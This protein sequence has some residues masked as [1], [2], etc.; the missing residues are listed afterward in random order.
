[1]SLMDFSDTNNSMYQLY[2]IVHIFRM[3]YSIIG[4]ATNVL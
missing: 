2:K 1:M 4:I 3:T